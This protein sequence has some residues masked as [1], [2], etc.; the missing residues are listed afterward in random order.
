MAIPVRGVGLCMLLIAAFD[1]YGGSG[2]QFGGDGVVILPLRFNFPIGWIGEISSIKP[3]LLY[4]RQQPF[5]I[6]KRTVAQPGSLGSRA[7]ENLIPGG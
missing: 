4:A 5:G 3:H 7:G 2:S 1:T 6:N